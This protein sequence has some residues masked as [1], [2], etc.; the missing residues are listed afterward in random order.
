MTWFSLGMI[1]ICME[2][3]FF[4]RMEMGYFFYWGWRWGN[5]MNGDGVQVAIFCWKGVT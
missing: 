2:V 1:F 5:G 3:G 4:I